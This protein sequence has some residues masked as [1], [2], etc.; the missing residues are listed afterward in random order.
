MAFSS[1]PSHPQSKLQAGGKLRSWQS[2]EQDGCVSKY[3][4][5]DLI[6]RPIHGACLRSPGQKKKKNRF[7]ASAAAAATSAPLRLDQ[8]GAPRTTLRAPRRSLASRRAQRYSAGTAIGWPACRGRALIGRR[9]FLC[10]CSLLPQRRAEVWLCAAAAGEAKARLRASALPSRNH[11]RRC[12]RV[13]EEE[14]GKCRSARACASAA[15]SL[16]GS[17]AMD[18]ESKVK[19]VRRRAPGV[20]EAEFT[21]PCLANAPRPLAA[22]LFSPSAAAHRKPSGFRFPINSRIRLPDA[23]SPRHRSGEAAAATALMRARL[24]ASPL[25][26]SE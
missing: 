8:V 25:V 3:L 14:G 13:E 23:P 2:A 5:H 24:V 15:A 4:C 20:G 6:R 26:T 17:T 10:S 19:K 22:P 9:S 18:L 21:C 16:R 1:P 12:Q 7:N 11:I